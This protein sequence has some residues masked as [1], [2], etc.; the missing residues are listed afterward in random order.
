MTSL[1][2]SRTDDTRQI[3]QLITQVPEFI[4]VIVLAGAANESSTPPGGARFV[5]ISVVAG[6][7]A[8]A[9]FMRKNTAAAVPS[10]DIT[11]G[12]GSVPVHQSILPYW[13]SLEDV[14]ALHFNSATGV[15]PTITLAYFS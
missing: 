14:T 13:F 2:P 6:G 8:G 12:T 3:Q 10:A 4:N 5:A 11:D 9:V 1:R 7:T 15:T